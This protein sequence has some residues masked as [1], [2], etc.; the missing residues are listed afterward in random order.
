AWSAWY[1]PEPRTTPTAPASGTRIRLVS[2][3]AGASTETEEAAT[4]DEAATTDR[5]DGPAELSVASSRCVSVGPF[6]ELAD[7]AAASARLRAA[8][9]EPS[10]RVA[11]GDIWV[12]YWVRIDAIPSRAEA[13]RILAKLRENG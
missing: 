13:N 5:L 1:A 4:S 3:V 6:P 11:E 7:A 8:G 12:G 10:Q 9:L 2:E